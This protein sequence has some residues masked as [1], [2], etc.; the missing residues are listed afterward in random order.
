MIFKF[1]PFMNAFRYFALILLLILAGT[2]SSAQPPAA[3]MDAVDSLYL[4]KPGNAVRVYVYPD[5]NVFPNGTYPI[6]D[7]GVLELP[8]LGGLNVLSMTKDSF[9]TILNTVYAAYVREINFQITPLIR[10]AFLG[11]FLTPGLYWVDPQK[12]LWES[13]QKS[14]GPV[15]EDGISKMAWLR[16]DPPELHDSLAVSFKAGTSLKNLGFQSGDLITVTPRPVRTSWE[17]FRDDALPLLTFAI[18]TVTTGILL[19]EAYQGGVL[20]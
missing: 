20:F 6:G 5:T 11:G 9:L 17:I 2:G 4:F 3:P 1:I 13:V 16:G 18:S 19:Y 15:R 8:L 14:G 7:D 12:S 10:I